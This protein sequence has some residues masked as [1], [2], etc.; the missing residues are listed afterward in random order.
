MVTGD[1]IITA[2][3]IAAEVGIITPNEE[4]I[5]LEGP[6]FTRL[7]G[8]VVCKK[9]EIAVCDCERDPKIA[10]KNNKSLRIDCIKN[11]EVF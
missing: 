10:E 11:M 9:C 6:E 8:G 5:A 1:N 2:K 4:Y 3:A 7:I